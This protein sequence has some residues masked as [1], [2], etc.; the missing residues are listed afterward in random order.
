MNER[1]HLEL[2]GPV[3]A[4]LV[5][6]FPPW[7]TVKDPTRFD[8]ERL[9][10]VPVQFS[11]GAVLVFTTGMALFFA[12]TRALDAQP[13]LDVLVAPLIFIVGAAQW[14]CNRVGYGAQ[15]RIASAAA[16]AVWFFLLTV[17]FYLV[18]GNPL[19]AL[20]GSPFAAIPGLGAGYLAGGLVA[21]IFLTG[22]LI[23]HQLMRRFRTATATANAALDNHAPW[24]NQL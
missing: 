3:L 1:P 2:E 23:D 4:T 16:G 19:A 21:G 18:A 24:D 9:Y 12:T 15:V 22:D 13:W 17:I 7:L 10:S 14:F 8:R 20:V 6:P 5:A 11:L